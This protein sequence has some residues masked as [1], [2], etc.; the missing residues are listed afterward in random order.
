MKYND[1]LI[2]KFWL[3]LRS[4]AINCWIGLVFSSCPFVCLCLRAWSYAKFVNT[5]SHK[6]LAGILSNLSLRWIWDRG[7][8]IRFWGQKV[9]GQGHSETTW[10]R[11]GHGTACRD[12]SH[13]YL[14]WRP[15]DVSWRRNCSF[16]VFL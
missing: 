5:I 9:K 13:R 12:L 14:H 11:R 1:E 4:P 2:S 6:S 15:S 7:E 8:L 3:R 16:E 10:L